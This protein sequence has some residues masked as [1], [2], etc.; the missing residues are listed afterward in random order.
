MNEFLDGILRFR[1]E[2]YEKNKAFF[3]SL[4][5]GQNP[6][7]LF[8]SCSDSR[9][10][11]TLITRTQPGEMFIIRNIANLVPFYRTTEDYV[12]TTSA[13]EYAVEKLQVKNIVVCGHSNCGGCGALYQDEAF[14]SDIPHV[15]KWLELAMPIRDSVLKAGEMDKEERDWLTEQMNVIQQLKNLKT[16]PF[17]QSRLKEGTLNIYGWY[18]LIEK[19][20]IYH[21][22]ENEKSFLLIE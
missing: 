19:G 20:E 11:P 6:H 17:V 10:D 18:Y 8:I 9:V 16:Y 14:F 7:T 3:H 21:Y 12:S 22:D 15:K 13:I 4:K 1:Q 5:E 2:D